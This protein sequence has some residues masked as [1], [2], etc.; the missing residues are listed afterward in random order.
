MFYCVVLKNLLKFTPSLPSVCFITKET[1]SLLDDV[2]KY[3]SWKSHIRLEER[4]EDRA[5][6]KF[7]LAPWPLSWKTR[8]TFRS[9][10]YNKQKK[11]NCNPSCPDVDT[12]LI[13]WFLAARAKSVPING[14]ILKSKA[15]ELKCLTLKLVMLRGGYIPMDGSQ[16]GRWGIILN[17]GLFLGRLPWKC[18][19]IGS[20]VYLCQL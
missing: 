6:F 17:I 12:A 9:Q 2:L 11:H 8:P 5:I 19:L 10:I 4:K 13:S 20:K 18:A 14:D 1:S 7:H 3:Q 16:G 15:E